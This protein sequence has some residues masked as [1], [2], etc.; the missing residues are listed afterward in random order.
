MDQTTQDQNSLGHSKEILCACALAAQG[1]VN[2][3]AIK[4]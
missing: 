1:A 4:I 2:L 3:Q